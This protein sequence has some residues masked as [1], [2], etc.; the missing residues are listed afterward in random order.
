MRVKRLT[1][2]LVVAG[3]MPLVP[4]LGEPTASGDPPRPNILMVM[5]DDLNGYVGAL[6]D[7]NAQTPNLDALAARGA[8]FTN[9]HSQAPLCG[10]SRA[11]ILSGLRPSTTGIYGQ[12][13]DKD[14]RG[15]SELLHYAKFLPEYLQ[16]HGYHTMGIGKLFHQHAPEGMLDESGGRNGGF[17]PKPPKGKYFKWNAEGTSTDWGAYPAENADMPDFR[18]AEW[19]VERLGRTYDQ[20]FFMGVGFLRPHVP[21]YVPQE[22]FDRYEAERLVMPAYRADDF[23]D[24]PAIA[25][26][27]TDLPQMPTTEWAIANGEWQNILEAY[28][29]SVTFVD[30]QVGKVLEALEASP[31]A[32]N[33][34]VILL[35]D[36]G[37]RLGEKGTF[38]KQCLWREGTLAPLIV[39]GPGIEGGRV[40]DDPVEL[41]DV[42]PTLLDLAN[43]PANPLNEGN[44]LRPALEGGAL[45]EDAVAIAT[46]G[47][48]NHAVI[49]KRHH[50][51]RYEDGAEELYD[52]EK[53]P[54]AFVN[55]ADD[56]QYADAKRWLRER[57][58]SRNR[59]WAPSSFVNTSEFFVTQRREQQAAY[60]FD[61]AEALAYCLWQTRDALD[62]FPDFDGMPATIPSGEEFWE[63][64]PS[65][66]WGWTNGFWPGILWYAHEAS[67]GKAFKAE[68]LEFSRALQG[69]TERE[70][71]SHDIGFIMTGSAMKAYEV[72]GD[73]FFRQMIIRGAHQLAGL[74]NPR[75]GAL[76]SWPAKV[77]NGEY[78]PHN[79]I[80][81]SMMNLELLFRASELTGDGRFKEMAVTH[82]N[83]VLQHHV[84]DDDTTCHLVV[85]DDE[86]GCALAQL[87][88]QGYAD[89][90][91]WAR[92]Q[93]WAIYG[94]TL[95]YRETNDAV[96]LDAARRFARAYLRRLPADHVPYWDFDDPAIPSA[97]RDASAAAITASALLELASYIPDEAESGSFYAAAER[98][99]ASLSSSA[100]RSF[101]RNVAFLDH[102]TGSKPRGREIDVPIIYADYYYLEA[103][104]RLKAAAVPRSGGA[105]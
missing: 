16:E 99:L 58:P 11:S 91:M 32:D 34:I 42:Y 14:L 85:F 49:S 40:I 51:I 104:L 2:L 56:P 100:Y 50:Y 35:S 74:F 21:W 43:L 44:S 63:L 69:V 48:N 86:T 97:P 79:T 68:A 105:N 33:T 82:A 6:G 57:L 73:E 67:G 64:K 31:H 93:A 75:V 92:G 71:N 66:R 54:H 12:I 37:Y 36:H 30:A 95:C 87:T 18:S 61:V 81:D 77:K 41:L 28:L 83:T 38:A 59:L 10:P 103:L 98:M 76:L 1:L 20:P 4:A 102:S 45:P 7:P 90:S 23:D 53:D 94:F 70:I 5:V 22:W 25:R 27:L 78:A 29:A 3:C 55:V 24:I 72:T 8:L 47:R 60:D 17:G 80:I 19:A 101:D 26:T 96:Y 65:D 39:N 89:D 9:A 52:S 62:A 46:Y 13:E 84:R 15:A 88:H